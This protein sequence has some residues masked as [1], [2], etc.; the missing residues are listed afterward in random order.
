M[1][2]SFRESIEVP[3]D[4]KSDIYAYAGKLGVFRHGMLMRDAIKAIMSVAGVSWVE[5]MLTEY[6]VNTDYVRK[7]RVPREPAVNGKSSA[8]SRKRKHSEEPMTS[9]TVS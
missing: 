1:K 2:V 7:P 6:P 4:R 5:L 8:K 3:A 9:E